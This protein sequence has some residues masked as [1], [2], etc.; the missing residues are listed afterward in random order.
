MSNCGNEKRIETNLK[1]Y[2]VITNLLHIDTINKSIQTKLKKFG[3]E[4]QSQSEE[5]KEKKRQTNLKN[6]GCECNLSSEEFKRKNRI[7]TLEKY[8]VEHSS[9]SSEIR[10]KQIDTKRKNK[11]IEIARYLNIDP[12]NVTCDSGTTLTI[13]NYCQEHNSFDITINQYHQRRTKYNNNVCTK[14]FPMKKHVSGGEIEL[15][16]FINSIIINQTNNKNILKNRFELD[17]YIP[18]F[19]VATEFDGI[20]WHSNIFKD[21]FYHLNKTDECEK[22]GIELIHI[23]EDEWKHKKEIVKSIIKSKLDIYDNIIAANDCT[24][25]E[26]SNNACT[27]FLNI[28]DIYEISDSNI[29]LGLFY[30]NDLVGVLS[31]NNKLLNEY[32][33]K[34]CNKLNTKIVDGE[35]KLLEYFIDKYKPKFIIAYADRRYSQGNIFKFLNF[36]HVENIEPNCIYYDKNKLIKV[37]SYKSIIKQDYICIYDCGQMKFE[38]KL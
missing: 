6:C 28:N 26:I 23:F 13:K 4:H 5:I 21:S 25:D 35:K 2:G 31:I 27:D 38:L 9:L 18:D 32:E 12:S 10:K 1:K 33:I 14:C 3:V 22:L 37:D 11:L 30:D 24:V 17:N 8:G 7:T 29:N 19:N 20:Y 15:K 16:N 36:I 34:F